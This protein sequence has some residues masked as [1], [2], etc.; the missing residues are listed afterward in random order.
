MQQSKS[1]HGADIFARRPVI[2]VLTLESAKQAVALARALVAGGLD[3]LEVTLRTAKALEAIRTIAQEVPEA[4]VGAGTVLAASQMLEAE[5]AGAKFLVSPGHSER[6]LAAADDC[7]LP[8]L[9]GAATASEVQALRE[10]GHSILKFFPAEPM[11]GAA[12]LKALQPVFPDVA[13]C[14]TGGINAIKAR[15]YLQLANVVAVGGS[16]VAPS[17]LPADGDFSAITSR[18]AEAARLERKYS[19]RG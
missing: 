5:R 15:D 4:I 16:W 9:L 17:N 8:W 12:T 19:A 18:A 6:L 10:R 13:F 14:P 7:A 11:G 1:S 3:V 2:P